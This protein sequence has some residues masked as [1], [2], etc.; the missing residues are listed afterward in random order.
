M[1][2]LA[3]QPEKRYSYADLLEL[4][5]EERYEII[6]GQLYHMASPTTIHQWVSGEIFRQLGNY[7]MG[8]RCKVFSAPLDVKLSGQ[9]DDTKEFFVVQPD[10]MVLCDSNKITRRN[11]L[12]APDLAI[13]ILSNSTKSRDRVLKLNFYQQFG[14]KEYWI[15]DVEGNEAS[16]YLLG[17]DGTYRLPKAYYLDEPIK[18]GILENCTIELKQFLED[19]EIFPKKKEKDGKDL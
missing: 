19:N 16:V 14:V 2:N 13:E 4:D 9:E 1:E 5:G 3:Y 12:G 11:I 15:I 8:K 6:D 18:V 17:E 7:L 10:I